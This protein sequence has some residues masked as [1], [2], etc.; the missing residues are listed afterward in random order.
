MDSHSIAICV[1]GSVLVI[2]IGTISCGVRLAVKRRNAQQSAE[3]AE[4]S[5]ARRTLRK[6]SQPRPTKRFLALMVDN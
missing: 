3:Q 6:I 4:H 1:M 5:D 2:A